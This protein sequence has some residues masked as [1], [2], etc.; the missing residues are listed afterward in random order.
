MKRF[1]VLLASLSV[2]LLLSACNQ[3]PQSQSPDLSTEEVVEETTQK[4]LE[5]ESDEYL[6]ASKVASELIQA[7][8]CDEIVDNSDGAY[9]FELDENSPYALGAFVICMTQYPQRT[10][11][12]C[13]ANIY[14]TAGPDATLYNPKRPLLYEDGVSVALFYGEN[15]QVEI[16]P[17]DSFGNP[18]TLV[19]DCASKVEIARETI[20]GS[21]TMY[22][23]YDS[24]PE[25]EQVETPDIEQVSMPN[26]VGSIDGNARN[27][28]RNNG[29]DFSFDIQSTGYNAQTSCLISGNNYIVGQQPSAGSTVENSFSTSVIVYVDCEW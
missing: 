10:D 7:G 4:A 19:S 18:E 11:E 22:G 21:V 14:V 5:W 26:L 16:S 23:Q 2:I 24:Y 20:G 3:P 8:V 29:Y 28:L 15:Y 12:T 27:W 17:L 6:N 25:E 1:K 13:P 9:G